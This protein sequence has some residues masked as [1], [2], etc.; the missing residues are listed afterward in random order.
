[1]RLVRLLKSLFNVEDS[2]DDL[3]QLHA[4]VV[5]KGDKLTAFVVD[6]FIGQQEVVLKSLGDYLTNVIN[7]TCPS[8]KIVAPDIAKTFVK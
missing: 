7:A 6:S 2:A 1:M 3:D 8:P 4:I 5:K